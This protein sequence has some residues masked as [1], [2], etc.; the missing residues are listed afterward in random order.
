[1]IERQTKRNRTPRTTPEAPSSSCSRSKFPLPPCAAIGAARMRVAIASAVP[2]GSRCVKR[3]TVGRTMRFCTLAL[4][5][6]LA[7]SCQGDGGA[8][9]VRWRLVDLSTGEAWDANTQ[10]IDYKGACCRADLDVNHT[11][12]S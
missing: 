3:A 10:S 5:L 7:A 2:R 9:S 8:V 6:L 12:A 4:A 1:M 11:C